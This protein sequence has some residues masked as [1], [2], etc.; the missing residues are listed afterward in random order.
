MAFRSRPTLTGISIGSVYT[1]PEWRGK[2]YA[3]ACVAALSQL[4]LDSGYRFCMLFTDLSNPTSNKIYQQIGYRPIG[5]SREFRF[6][7]VR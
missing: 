4:C 5:E 3:S 6:G 2:G 1:P 7:D